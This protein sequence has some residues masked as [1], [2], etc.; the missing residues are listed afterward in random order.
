LIITS[1]GALLATCGGDATI[2][3]WD[4]LQQQCVHVIT[5]HSQPVWK[6]KYQVSGDFLLS[7]SMDHTIR[8]YDTHNNKARMSYRAHVDSVNAINFIHMNPNL[9]ISGSADK[10]VSLWDMRS[11]ICAQT[12]F[13]HK[14]SVNGAVANMAGTRIGSCDSDGIVKLWDIRSQREL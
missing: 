6:V 4:I 14:N 8:L 13:G 3:I 5:D 2:R 10:T 11:N 12:F 7:A 1:S 9:F